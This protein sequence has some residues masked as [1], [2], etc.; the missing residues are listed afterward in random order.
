MSP[1]KLG[2]SSFYTP[3]RSVWGEVKKAPKQYSKEGVLSL[4]WIEGFDF[5]NY[6]AERSFKLYIIKTVYLTV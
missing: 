4:G 2:Q 6:I 5:I 3:A 1:V